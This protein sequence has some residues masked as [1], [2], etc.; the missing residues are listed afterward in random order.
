MKV[1]IL[2]T[3]AA[4]PS[5]G[6][7]CSGFL[8][9]E[10]HIKLLVDCGTGVL[11]NLQ[12]Y[13]DLT[14]ITHIFIS[15]MHADHFF[16][17]IPFRYALRYGLETSREA[18]PHLFI[19]PGGSQALQQVI[20]PFVESDNFFPE[21]FDVTEYEPGKLIKLEDL[22]LQAIPVKHY[23]PSYGL[24][25]TG[26]KKLA[27][28]SD[29]APCSGLSQVAKDAELFVCNVGACLINNK[30]VSWGHLSP[31][32]SG[33][34]ARDAGVKKLLLSHFWP[35]CE[36]NLCLE[37]VAGSFGGHVELAEPLRTYQI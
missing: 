32:E 13:L 29:S 21:V 10:G 23:I 12:K 27:Y 36:R 8:V 24:I 17:L 1:T 2:G 4:Y 6:E 22:K 20:S 19:P 9:E 30:F 3:G 14:S 34:L 16:D 31:A 11:S 26:S 33:I 25:V 5:A 35:S 37:E 18:R 7:A 15:H 28:S